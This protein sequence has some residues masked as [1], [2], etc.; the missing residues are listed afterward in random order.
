VLRTPLTA[1]V[2]IRG[3]MVVQLKASSSVASSI[4]QKPLEAQS[5]RNERSVPQARTM[6]TDRRAPDQSA[7]KLISGVNRMRAKSG[8]ASSN[9]IASSSRPRQCSH[10][11]M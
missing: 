5:S 9:A 11:G 6:R 2:S 4:C 7:A 3:M 8:A 10:T 1:T